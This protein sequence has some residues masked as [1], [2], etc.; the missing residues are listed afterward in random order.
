MKKTVVYDV[1]QYG[2]N[3]IREDTK[4][5]ELDFCIK[6]GQLALGVLTPPEHSKKG[7][8]PMMGEKIQ[9]PTPP[10]P[11]PTPPLPLS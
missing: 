2:E 3:Q 9:F 11:P 10:L 8:D 5:A 7:E 4:W 1:N 6:Y